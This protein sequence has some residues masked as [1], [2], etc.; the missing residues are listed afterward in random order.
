MPDRPRADRSSIHALDLARRVR[1]ERQ[2]RLDGAR[3][4]ISVI[5]N[6]VYPYGNG[7]SGV[8]I[9]RPERADVVPGT[10]GRT[11]ASKAV[12]DALDRVLRSEGV[13][14]V[15]DDP[16]RGGHTTARLGDPANGVHVVQLELNRAL[17]MDEARH[18]RLP[19]IGVFTKLITGFLQEMG[20]QSVEILLPYRLA[21]E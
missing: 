16:Y 7:E 4:R 10:R 3:R 6:G 5:G 21:A 14:V 19:T 20:S 2:E 1:A 15:H 17:Y 18:E 11:T 13:R 12:I 9:L 8:G